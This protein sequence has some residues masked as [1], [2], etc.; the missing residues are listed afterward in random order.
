VIDC[1]KGFLIASVTV[2]TFLGL[3]VLRDYLVAHT[4][5]REHVARPV[6]QNPAVP[7]N[8]PA[9]PPPA[10]DTPLFP[11]FRGWD[12]ISPSLSSLSLSCF[13]VSNPAP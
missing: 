10:P 3:M 5:L 11:E 13:S 1:F 12:G 9:P 6:R 4:Q 2:A 7:E 8:P